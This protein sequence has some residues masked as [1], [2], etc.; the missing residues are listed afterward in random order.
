MITYALE[1]KDFLSACK[2]TMRWTTKR[3]IV[4]GSISA[5]CLGLGIFLL[6]DPYLFGDYYLVGVF[7]GGWLTGGV[8]GGWVAMIIARFLLIPYRFK[9][10]FRKNS[11]IRRTA[12]LS[13]DDK[14]LTFESENGHMLIPWADFVKWR[15]NDDVIFVYRS[16]L[17]GMTIPKRVFDKPEKLEELQGLLT[18]KVRREL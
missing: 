12:T 2:L 10:K 3:W 14:G 17:I 6:K 15:E 11:S 7:A 8:V 13:W 4:L 1:E 16:R 5:V 9:R 18:K